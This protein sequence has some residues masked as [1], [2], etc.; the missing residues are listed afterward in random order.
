MKAVF[1]IFLAVLAG[2]VVGGLM[3]LVIP[4]QILVARMVGAGM[5]AAGFS[6]GRLEYLS[7]QNGALVLHGLQLDGTSRVSRIRLPVS[8]S[9]LAKL[10]LD[11]I[12]VSGAHLE[13]SMDENGKLRLPGLSLRS[14]GGFSLPFLP[15][16]KIVASDVDVVV[17]TPAGLVRSLVSATLV[18]SSGRMDAFGSGILNHENTGMRFSFSGNLRHD[19][20]LQVH[21]DGRGNFSGYGLDVPGMTFSARLEKAMNGPEW[22]LL[23]KLACPQGTALGQAFESFGLEGNGGAL[24]YAISSKVRLPMM[25]QDVSMHADIAPHLRDM[26]FD[27]EMKGK[28]SGQLSGRLRKKETGQVLAGS[29]TGS[30]QMPQGIVRANADDMDLNLGERTFSAK[31]VQME[32]PEMK[33][34]AFRDVRASLAGDKEG[35]KGTFSMRA[36]PPLWKLDLPISGEG[37]TD[38]KTVSLSF[39]IPETGFSR[40]RTPH[41]GGEV[42]ATL[43]GKIQDLRVRA[44]GGNLVVAKGLE[45]GSILG[46]GAFSGGEITADLTRARSRIPKL[47]NVVLSGRA[48]AT[49]VSNILFSGAVGMEGSKAFSAGFSG[50]ADARTQDVQGSVSGLVLQMGLLSLTD[51]QASLHYG[52]ERF[53]ATDVS[54]RAY[55]GDVRLQGLELDMAKPGASGE[56]VVLGLDLSSFFEKLGMKGLSGEGRVDARMPFRFE[57]DRLSI[58][59]GHVQGQGNGIIHYVRQAQENDPRTK[60]TW[61]ILKNLH[62]TNLSGEMSGTL[63]GEQSLRLRVEGSNP[64]VYDGRAVEW[65]LDLSGALDAMVFQ[66]KAAAD[67]MRGEVKP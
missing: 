40:G 53:A 42:S 51:G 52:K 49:D 64:Q 46:R 22:Q 9:S 50:Q 32:L 20:M 6:K 30:L 38:W 37:R 2:G 66:G 35:A 11:S 10:R 58:E 34:V 29:M 23:G 16:E 43:S 12:Q 15:V 3:A 45:I 24:G 21:G 59:N 60:E 57:K 17:K 25:V 39:Q 36:L 55:G 5:H 31:S 63:G 54:A 26:T 47:G 61:E 1:R 56:I 27:L 41:M 44:D 4:P 33:G 67:L 18:P 62:Y 13:I 28:V 8:L 48:S 19:G 14:G 7:W 65:N